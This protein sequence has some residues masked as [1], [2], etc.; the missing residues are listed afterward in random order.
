MVQYVFIV[1]LVM[2]KVSILTSSCINAFLNSEQSFSFWLKYV[3]SLSLISAIF[4][5]FNTTYKESLHGDWIGDWENPTKEAES[6]AIVNTIFFIEL[7]LI[8]LK[9]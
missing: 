6:N 7:F 5:V 3:N 2:F 1:F 8:E 4:L 9:D